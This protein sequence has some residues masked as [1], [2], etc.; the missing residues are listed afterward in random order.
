MKK[1]LS[2]LLCAA[3]LTGCG[4][5]TVA[6]VTSPAAETKP[7][8]TVASAP[9]ST[10]VEYVSRFDYVTR[11]SLSDEGIL[12]DSLDGGIKENESVF[13]THDIIYYEDR[14][15]YDSGNPYGEGSDADKHTADEGAYRL[16]HRP[17][18]QHRP[19]FR[20][21]HGSGPWPHHRA[22]YPR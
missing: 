1:I 15:T 14:D 19:Q 9:V 7:T 6:E 21:H 11:I 3:L 5:G 4:T 22:G 10:E 16:C 8:A 2:V 20:L 13:V 17:P 18:P 12:V